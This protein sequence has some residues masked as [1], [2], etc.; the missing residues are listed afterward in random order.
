MGCH[1]R[2]KEIY[3]S[4]VLGKSGNPLNKA[5]SKKLIT[6]SEYR[7]Y[8]KLVH[9]EEYDTKEEAQNREVELIE[10]FKEHYG[11]QCLN[12]SKGNKYGK[13]GV[14]CSEETKRK[15]S[16]SLMGENHPMYGKHLSEETKRKMSEERKGIPL[17]E[18][19]V[20]ALKEAWKHRCHI[21]PDY[22]KK[23]R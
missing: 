19:N 23:K 12:K 18:K 11:N 10:K 2:K 3:R 5:Y 6:Y 1:C 8:C 13:K 20:E 22:V 14:S 9:I 16:I 7:E 15:L 17:S 21:T 4:E